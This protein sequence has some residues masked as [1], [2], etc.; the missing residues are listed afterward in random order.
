VCNF[1]K[2]DKMKDEI[3]RERKIGQ[4]GPWNKSR[5]QEITGRAILINDR[6]FYAAKAT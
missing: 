4:C 1:E 5:G 6:V 2:A 3:K